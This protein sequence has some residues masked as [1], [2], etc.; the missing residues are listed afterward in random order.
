LVAQ[1]LTSNLHDSRFTDL[2]VAPLT[3]MLTEG[4]AVRVVACLGLA[5][6]CLG[7]N[8]CSVFGRKS[9]TVGSPVSRA[10]ASTATPSDPLSVAAPDRSTVP[11]AATGLLAGQVLDSYNQHPAGVY[12]QVVEARDPN[13]PPTAPIEVAADGQGYFTVQ[14]LQPGHHYQLIARGRNGDRTLAGTTWATPPDPKILIQ[15]SEDFATPSTPAAPGAPAWAGPNAA[16]AV[17]PPPLPQPIAQQPATADQGWS[18]GA[19]PAGAP[20]GPR[21]AA[22]IG[23]PEGASEGWTG[24][25][26][27]ASPA[28]QPVVNR[29]ESVAEGPVAR[30]DPLLDIRSDPAG[31]TSVPR[32]DPGHPISPPTAAPA[33]VPSCVLT[34]QTLHNFAL[35]D[36]NGQPWEYRRQHHG[37]LTLIDFWGTSCVHCLHS[38]PH[39]NIL[40]QR[41]GP[42]GLEVLGVAYEEGSP[43]EQVQKVNR[44]RQRLAVNYKLLMGSDWNRCPV[45]TQFAVNLLPTLVLLDEGGRII[46]RSEGLDGPKI[47]ELDIIIRQR[48]GVR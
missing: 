11:V 9:P 26:A 12:I 16:N 2:V 20:A 47:R 4:R 10:G 35:Y 46:W 8:G 19:G 42:Y 44:V 30:A 7:L 3:R 39:L 45:R 22:E 33:I 1:G 24:A 43:V 21:R 6:V 14:G 31:A 17:R 13:S 18:P 37:R 25:G 5:A 38:I 48:L 41:Y 29:P 27:P 28:P 40:Q 36:V 23:R 15:V 32:Q 34:G